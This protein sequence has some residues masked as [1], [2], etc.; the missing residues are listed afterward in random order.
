MKTQCSI[1]QVT[2]N[3]KPIQDAQYKIAYAL[4]KCLILELSLVLHEMGESGNSKNEDKLKAININ[5][6]YCVG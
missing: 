2:K 4:E 1:Q 3:I 5:Y 6:I